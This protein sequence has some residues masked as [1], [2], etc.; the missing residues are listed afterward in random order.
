METS[1]IQELIESSTNKN[2]ELLRIRRKDITKEI[3]NVKKSIDPLVS[4]VTKL[5]KYTDSKGMILVDVGPLYFNSV[6]L[7]YELKPGS[8]KNFFI[9]SKQRSSKYHSAYRARYTIQNNILRQPYVESVYIPIREH[10]WDD[11]RF[12]VIVNFKQK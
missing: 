2:I 12:I 8:Y 11:H 3:A 1:Q 9:D 7:T 10:Y 6:E 4:K 5:V